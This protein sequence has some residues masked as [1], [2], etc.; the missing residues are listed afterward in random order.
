M[1]ARR[2]Y[3]TTALIQ[4]L[5]TDRR[6]GIGLTI[7]AVVV[8]LILVGIYVSQMGSGAPEVPGSAAPI[9]QSPAEKKAALDEAIAN[10]TDSKPVAE[11]EAEAEAEAETPANATVEILMPRK[12]QLWVDDE[13]VGKVKSHSAELTPGEHTFKAK[14]GKRVIEQTEVI[15]AGSKVQLIVSPRKK[16]I[17]VKMLE[18]GTPPETAG[19]EGSA[20]EP[21]KDSKGG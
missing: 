16:K 2:R 17:V 1:N 11:P 9:T 10:D 20:E 15:A 18:A 8:M 6:K 13:S 5:K 19:D 4:D 12:G 3:D 21:A 14:I 7:A